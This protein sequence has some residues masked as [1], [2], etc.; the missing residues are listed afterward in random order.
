MLNGCLQ[1]LDSGLIPGNRNA[2]NIGPELQKNDLF[3]FPQ[4]SIQT[5]GLK[6]CSITSFGFGQKGAQA[7]VV[8]PR[9]LFATLTKNDY[10]A[11]KTKALVRQ[12]KATRFFQ[13]GFR[14]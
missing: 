12:R 2:D 14:Y 3:V 6:A 4:N 11:Y 9:Y 1:A 10:E 8:H 5:T 7:I 13:K